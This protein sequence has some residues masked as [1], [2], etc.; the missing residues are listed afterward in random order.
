VLELPDRYAPSLPVFTAP[1]GISSL[2]SRVEKTL[3]EFKVCGERLVV[4]VSGGA[5]SIVLLDVLNTLRQSLKLELHVAHLDHGL[6]PDSDVD[7][8]LVERFSRQCGLPC[9]RETLAPGRCTENG[10]SSIE[11]AARIARYEFLDRTAAAVGAHF[12]VLGHHADDQAETVLMRLLR[13]S[14]VTGLAGMASLRDGRY[15]RPLLSSKRAEIESYALS[16][17][18][19]FQTDRTNAD[20]RHVRNRIRH[21]LLPELRRHFNPS[22]VQTLCRTATVLGDEDRYLADCARSAIQ[23]LATKRT[24]D[25]I[26]LDRL[27]FEGQHPAVRRRMLHQLIADFEGGSKCGFA[28]IEQIVK[29]AT[30]G[31]RGNRHL[32]GNLWYQVTPDELILRRSSSRTFDIGVAVPGN[33][34]IRELGL[35]LH[36][37][38]ANGDFRSIRNDLGMN[39]AAFDADL[40]GVHLKLRSVRNGDRFQPLGMNGHKRVN[41]YL[42]DSG[43]PKILRQDVLLMT[44]GDDIVWVAGLRPA[45]PFR[46]HEKTRKIMIVDLQTV[47]GPS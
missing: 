6:R 30:E 15:L 25:V 40:T 22:I 41:D 31:C 39:R 2:R 28:K 3:T 46:V 14:G 17:S 42:T 5:D 18:L 27:G 29:A 45:H 8:D 12:V 26:I 13:G 38:I 20:I 4:A 24:A 1:E 33:T 16:R 43:V 10:I 7:A 9:I 37:T 47:E 23:K 19:Q 32:L 44:S 34:E 11:N 36:T 21:R 35:R